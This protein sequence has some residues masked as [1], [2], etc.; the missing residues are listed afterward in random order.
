MARF[1]GSRAP[2]IPNMGR[3]GDTPDFTP[4]SLSS[5]SVGTSAGSAQAADSWGSIRENSP[6]YGNLA[7]TGQK[8]RAEERVANTMAEADMQAA[9]I[10]AV[11]NTVAARMQKEGMEAQ[12][13]AQEKAGMFSAIGG[14]ASAAIGLSDETTKHTIERIEDACSIL[15]QLNPVSFYYKDEYSMMPERKHYGFIAQ[16]YKEQMP[17]ATYF[18]ESIGKLCIDTGELIGL[19]VR[20]NQQLETRVTKLEAERSLAT[21]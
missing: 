6:D 10:G 18:D 11:S 4:M 20:A 1:A 3:S 19:L 5:G 7:A 2:Q 8:L 17:D 16:E 9:G 15:R 12:A 13:A 14:I 21:V